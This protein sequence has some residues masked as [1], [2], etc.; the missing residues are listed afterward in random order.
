MKET[1]VNNNQEL[2]RVLNNISLKNSVLDFEWQFEYKPFVQNHFLGWFV[3]VSFERPDTITGQIGRG[4]GRD[5]F[6]KIG[7]T[8]SGVVK[9]CWLL[10]ELMI[11]HELMESFKYEGARIFNPHHTVEE[12]AK[13][14]GEHK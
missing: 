9:T 4:V 3:R 7:T 2:E 6:I 5:E 12:L 13:L 14:A 8:I 10:L 1:T 11:R